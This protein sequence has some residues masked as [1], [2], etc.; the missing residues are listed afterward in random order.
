MIIMKIIEFHMRNMKINQNYRNPQDNHETNESQK[1]QKII[2][3][4]MKIVEFHVRIT[5]IIKILESHNRINK[6]IEIIIF[7]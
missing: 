3:R 6:I 4:I 5:K 7:H 2:T 1:N